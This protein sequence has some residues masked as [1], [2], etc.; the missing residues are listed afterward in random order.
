MMMKST[1]SLVTTI[2]ARKVFNAADFKKEVMECFVGCSKNIENVTS[3]SLL[4]KTRVVFCDEIV[5]TRRY[6]STL[7]DLNACIG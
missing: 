2:V 3:K 5:L 7:K 6:T 1:H 4:L